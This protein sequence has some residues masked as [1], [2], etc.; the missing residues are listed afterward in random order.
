MD[1]NEFELFAKA[2]K[3]ILLLQATLEQMDELKGTLIYKREIKRDMNNLESR[4]EA[5][6]KPVIKQMAKDEEFIMMQISRGID[7]ILDKTIMD[8]HNG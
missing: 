5:Y 6:I 1:D 4:I 2:V 3:M 7:S 8:I